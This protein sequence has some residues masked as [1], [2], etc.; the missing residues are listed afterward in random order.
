MSNVIPLPQFDQPGLYT[1]ATLPKQPP[2]AASCFSTGWPEMDPLL[3]IYPGQ[4]IVT[5]GAPESGK[6]T[7]WLNVICNMAHDKGVRTFMYVPENEQQIGLQLERIWGVRQGFKYFV[8]DQCY[9]Q[10]AEPDHYDDAPKTLPWILD[11]AIVTID[12]GGVGFLLLDP[13]N[14]IEVA[15]PRDMSMTDYIAKCL[16]W[17]KQ[18]A[19][20]YHVAI[21]LVAHPTKEGIKDGKAPKLSDVE[22]SAAWYA[23]ADNGLIVVRDAVKATCQVISAKARFSPDSGKRG[24]CFFQVDE[25]TGQFTPLMEAP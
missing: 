4:F 14:E 2:I 9:I 10:S 5:T 12:R 6:S 19:R 22:N 1:I 24:S 3:R 13:W 21:C 17:L 18:F 20:A 7:F 8:E 15:K 23:K 25:Y 11:Q 16:V